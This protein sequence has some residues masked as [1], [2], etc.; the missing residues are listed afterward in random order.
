MKGGFNDFLNKK[1][2]PYANKLAANRALTAIR[3]GVGLAV[4]LIIIGSIPLI[5]SALPIDNWAEILKGISLP[6][7]GNLSNL[8]KGMTDMTFGIMVIP[9]VFGIAYSYTKSCI[10][11]ELKSIGSGFVALGSFLTITPVI[12]TK[13]GIAGIDLTYLGSK[14]LIVA[15]VLGLI[16]AKIFSWF[17]LHNVEIKMPESVPPAISKTF[18]ALIPGV[19]IVFMWIII[20]LIIGM[21]GFDNIH[22]VILE[23]LEKPLSF[24]G[25]TLAGTL[26]AVG[27]NSLV[28]SIGVH[29]TVINSAMGPIWL[30]NSDANRL[31]LQ[32]GKELPHIVTNSFIANF[33][34]MGGSGAT[35]CLVLALF[36]LIFMKKGSA[37]SKTLTSVATAP[38]VFNINEPIMFGYPVVF[39]VAIL[40]PFI[41]VPMIFATTTYFSMK[42]GIVAKPTGT[43]LNWT[44]PPIISGYLATNSISGSI[45]QIFNLIIGTLIYLPFVS[46]INNKQLLAEQ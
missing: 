37:E 42:L 27:L 7:F 30:M 32:Q 10:Q 21:F 8:L 1:I 40:I 29:G 45:L 18:S 31:A 36:I 11:D 35:A 15:I 14:G 26:I 46:S 41:I 17:I 12:V 23:V 22:E 24:L 3:D 2:L 19:V 9:T 43:V 6:Y 28:W 44:M 20:A 25:G 13:E 38:A 16:S 34:Y 39:N 4:T 5:I 33:T